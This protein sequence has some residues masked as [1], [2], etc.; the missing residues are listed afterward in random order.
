MNLSSGVLVMCPLKTNI[1]RLSNDGKIKINWQVHFE[2]P[3]SL[4][5]KFGHIILQLWQLKDYKIA[6]WLQQALV[7]DSVA[8]VQHITNQLIISKI[9]L[10]YELESIY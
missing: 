3:H 10:V 7:S 8:A 1:R 9:T 6:V 2:L 5:L 4:I